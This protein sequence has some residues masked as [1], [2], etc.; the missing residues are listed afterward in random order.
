MVY[1]CAYFPTPE[2]GLEEAQ[3]AKM[4]HVARKVQLKPG[5][6]VIEAGCGWGALSLHM[7]EHFGVN[8]R[9]F[10]ISK[11][12]VA[13]ARQQAQERGLTDRVEFIEDD[14]R[15]ITGTC[16][17]FVSV[18]M[19]EHVGLENYRD[20][21]GVIECCLKPEGLGL[22]HSIS[23]NYPSPMSPWMEREIF[24]GAYIPALSEM[25]NVFQPWD[26]SVLDVENLRLHYAE[27]LAHWLERFEGVVD[28]V[29]DRF[30]DRF[31]RMWRL[32]LAAS[33]ASFQCGVMQLYQIVFAK[34]TSNA[35]PRTREYMYAQ[36]VSQ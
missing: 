2:T 14:Y 33:Q 27:T 19:L 11:E 9:A 4:D 5:Q 12:Q 24:P 30:D 16:D 15:N 23:R 7:A 10:N 3:L 32:Y 35:V 6:K 13:Y 8:V 25:L 20:L 31:V 21:G 1:T 29:R 34:G 36:G 17:A 28:Q 22:I 18:G 26:M